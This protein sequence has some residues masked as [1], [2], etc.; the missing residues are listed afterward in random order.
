[1][2]GV[3]PNLVNATTH[4]VHRM[5][6]ADDI[7]W[8]VDAVPLAEE[9]AP[10]DLR[11]LDVEELR[12][13]AVHLREDLRSVRAVLRASLDVIARQR[14]HIT[15]VARV[16]DAQREHLRDRHQRRTT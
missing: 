14:I 15:R 4:D 5:V 8:T 10:D 12:R 16:I 11:A 2:E 7:R 13:Y 3:P 9:V 6:R 1:M